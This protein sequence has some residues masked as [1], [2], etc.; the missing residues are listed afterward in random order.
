MPRL[1]FSVDSALLSEL[2]E[3]LVE[4]THVALLE[5]V[6]NAYDA[7]ATKAI[8]GMLPRE[9]DY[10]ITVADNGVGMTLSQ[11]KRYWMRIATTNKAE[12]SISPV[13]GRAKSGSKGIGRF[14]CRRLGSKLELKTTARLEDGRYETTE[15]SIDWEDYT[16]GTDVTQ[17]TCEG[18]TTHAEEGSTG[19][20][21]VIR[22]GRPEE[23]TKRGWRVLKRRLILLV[24]NRGA[25]RDGFEPDPG[26]NVS[27]VAP[28]FEESDVVDQ[29]EQLMDAG[30]GR[31]RLT[32]DEDGKAE[33][34][35]NAKRLGRKQF[36]PPDRHPELAGITADIA[37]LPG[38][39]KHFRD[40]KAI[41][42]TQLRETL[43]EWG[44][45]CIRVDGIRVPP[46]GEGSD[47][48]LNIA[49][50]RARRK[51]TTDFSPVRAL[52]AKLRG[53]DEGRALLNMLSAK[54]Y[55]GEVNIES[56]NELFTM[57]ASRDGFVGEEGIRALR[58]V[59]RHGI[60]WST[61][62]RD[63]YLRLEEGEEAKQAREGFAK[64]VD[65]PTTEADAVEDAVTY[66]Q[67]EVK[68]IASQLPREERQKVVR[69]VARAT[70][71]VLKEDK[72]RREELRHLRLV[73][74]TSSLLLIFSH[75]VKSLLS[76]LDEYE[77]GLSSL[78][79]RL[80]KK[81]G[82]RVQKMRDSFKFTKKRFGDLLAMTSLLA[83]DSR[84]AEPAR[85]ALKGRAERAAAC[86]RLIAGN[87]DIDIALDQVPNSLTVG[88]ML[89]A[90][91]YSLLLNV[92]SNSI[93]ST[94]AAGSDRHIAV[95]AAR[96]GKQ[97]R[98]N[99]L[100]TGLGAPSDTEDLFTPFVADPDGALYRG[101]K[102][103]LN[104][105]DE[106]VVGT[107][108]GLGLS[109]VKEIVDAHGGT[110]AFAKPPEGWNCNLEICLP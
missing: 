70:E 64:A 20:Q 95:A 79:S 94:I 40:P 71:F 26:F 88:P 80:P 23:W 99:V 10:E 92:F 98:I 72:V 78:Q 86:F 28:D 51:T 49:Y 83:I 34:V 67:K 8:V 50:D 42:I 104:P 61:V 110:I 48:W 22:G 108:S 19:T 29:R 5:L 14:S 93:K 100:D 89:E 41:A 7:D 9:P 109:I 27:L 24:S 82:E 47:D 107:G 69:N 66:V 43:R 77:M 58:Q 1:H 74:S 101:L 4:S 90:E 39:K 30:W 63:Y 17:I 81:A 75:E 13:Y 12:N 6:K 45:V 106:Y 62:Y 46:Y 60:D 31:L 103:R 11:L 53:V 36:T 21:L 52:A 3:R 57:K 85:L 59:I 54:S 55:V 15:L 18:H 37:I 87:Y 16:P 25:H 38:D 65:S 84:Q 97:V 91:L 102:R 44:G 68:Q 33:W 2:G 76:V 96:S 56:P 35:M 105:E 73:A 32:I